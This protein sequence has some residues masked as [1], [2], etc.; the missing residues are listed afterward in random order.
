[1]ALNSDVRAL[2]Q[3]WQQTAHLCIYWLRRNLA[4]KA[5][6]GKTLAFEGADYA[7]GSDSLALRLFRVRDDV[8]DDVLQRGPQYTACLLVDEPRGAF[9]ITT[10]SQT[11]QLR[12]A[13]GCWS[14]FSLAALLFSEPINR[15]TLQ[16]YNPRH[17]SN[18]TAMSDEEY[19][20][21]LD[22]A[23][24]LAFC[25]GVLQIIMALLQVG[26]LAA[27]LSG[28]LISGFMCA[29]A[30]HIMASQFKILFG[31][32][33]PR[34]YGPGNLLLKFYNLCTHITEANVA[35]VVI[36]I[37]CIVVLHVF[38]M[39]INPFFRRKLKFPIPVELMLVVLSTVLSTVISH[40]VGFS[41][42]WGVNV[43]GKIPSGLPA[44]V[45]PTFA[46][47]ADLVSDTFVIGIIVFAINAG[48]V[49]TYA[50][51]F[52][53]DVL[54]NQ[55]LLALGISN[56]FASFF[57]CHT[58]SGALART[59]V[60][61]TI[62][63]A[64][65][66][67]SLISCGIFLIILFFIAPYLESLPRAV[68]GCIVCV[69][70]TS[71]FKKVLDL[72]RLWKVSKI[73]AIC[74]RFASYFTPS[75]V[76]PNDLGDMQSSEIV[77]TCFVFTGP[78]ETFIYWA[79]SP[80]N[81]WLGFDESIWLVSFLTTFAVDITYGIGV[82]FVYSILTVVSR[83]QYGGRFLLGEARNSDLYSELKRFEESVYRLSGVDPVKV[84]RDSQK[85]ESKWKLFSLHKSR[86]ST[87]ADSLHNLPTEAVGEKD[88]VGDMVIRSST[89]ESSDAEV[90]GESGEAS[91][92][93][94][95][96][97]ILDASGW[98]FTD[99]VGLRG[100]K[101]MIKKY[102]EVEVTILVA[103]LRPRLREMFAN[104]GVFSL[105]SEEN[106][107]V[108]VHDAVL[109]ALAELHST[110][111]V[112]AAAE[113]GMGGAVALRRRL[114]I[115]EVRSILETDPDVTTDLSMGEPTTTPIGCGKHVY[116]QLLLEKSTLEATVTV[117]HLPNMAQLLDQRSYD[118]RWTRVLSSPKPVSIQGE[119]SGLELPKV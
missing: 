24:T 98:M 59:A 31:I 26:F 65:Q 20:F 39:Y 48:L 117:S 53:Y 16:Y 89:P 28:P 32:K 76:L 84:Q 92:K 34:V 61:A 8:V 3:H 27:Y 1:M 5:V 19:A 105:L 93:P 15:L 116:R 114:T 106:F 68:L 101:E 87:P 86:S 51:E 62:G 29:S 14:T 81:G 77:S 83:S 33:L 22:L 74:Q 41:S 108:S 13:R 110:T 7:H 115:D 64:S 54:D 103:A 2:P 30:F 99:T 46:H 112:A 107:F 67:A 10:Q 100:I 11:W 88:R 40:F 102:T 21:R 95:R 70:L 113:D 44:P 60:V 4:T 94:L 78:V 9:H 42:R 58:A 80:H 47:F 17:P 69:A 6:E 75:L 104:S 45:V 43:I 55:E 118:Q 66:I 97:I 38:R 35:T 73:D 111:T 109:V 96:Y 37:I 71:T 57:Q 25:V 91:E 85:R 36:C 18:S 12:G 79:I 56:T 23:L 52:G 90:D 119:T 82:G 72:K 50:S 49:K 63:M